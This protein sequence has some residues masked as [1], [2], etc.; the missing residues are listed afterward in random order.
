MSNIYICL[1]N[2]IRVNISG[3]TV[4]LMKFQIISIISRYKFFYLSWGSSISIGKDYYFFFNSVLISTLNLQHVKV[5]QLFCHP[6]L[7]ENTKKEKLSTLCFHLLKY[8]KYSNVIVLDVILR[9]CCYF[10]PPLRELIHC[11]QQVSLV[12]RAQKRC[13]CVFKSL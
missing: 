2:A 12:R 9:I 5:H 3:R 7:L 13:P 11:S 10:S 6:L 8:Q 4:C 1:F